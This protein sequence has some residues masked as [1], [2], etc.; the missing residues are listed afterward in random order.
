MESYIV[1]FPLARRGS[2][3]SSRA[4]QQM[5]DRHDIL[6]TGFLLGRAS[7]SRLQ[8]VRPRLSSCRSS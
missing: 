4:L 6:R 5:V 1:A 7:S 8:V 2:I 3:A